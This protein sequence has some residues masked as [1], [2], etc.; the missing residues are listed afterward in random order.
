MA[1]NTARV[2]LRHCG[3]AHAAQKPALPWHFRFCVSFLTMVRAVQ[4]AIHEVI[5][6]WQLAPLFKLATFLHH[7]IGISQVSPAPCTFQRAALLKLAPSM[8]AS[9]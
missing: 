7:S 9:I 8:H 5:R 4:D 2:L 1:C 6:A 3:H